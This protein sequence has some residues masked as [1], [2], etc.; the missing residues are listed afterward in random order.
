MENKIVNF[1]HNNKI[2]EGIL[3]ETQMTMFDEKILKL[4]LISNDERNELKL[5]KSKLLLVKEGVFLSPYTEINNKTEKIN[6]NK[7]SDKKRNYK[8]VNKSNNLSL[9]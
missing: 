4:E 9:F 3:L 2:Y 7:N 5:G 1:K 6:Q 8:K